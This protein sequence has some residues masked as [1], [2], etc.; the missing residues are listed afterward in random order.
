VSVLVP[1]HNYENFIERSLASALAQD[2]PAELLEIVVV[3]DG[4]TDGTA[5]V[6]RDV[7]VRHAGRIT[8]VQQAN[9]GQLATVARASAE[10][11]GELHTFLD[12][13]DEWLPTKVSRQV[14][15]FQAQPRTWLVFCDMTTIDV[16]GRVLKQSLYEP[17]EP[18]MDP[19]RLYARVLRSN[20]IYGGSSMYRAGLIT[21]LPPTAESWDWW[22]SVRTNEARALGYAEI[23]FVPQQLALYRQHPDNMLL[24]ATGERLIALRRRQLRFQLWAFRNMSLD[25]LSAGDLRFIAGGVEWFASTAM[26]QAGTSLA[27]L[28]T[29]D[30]DERELALDWHT[31]AEL[32]LG[33][34]AVMSAARMQLQAW[35]W[36]PLEHRSLTRFFELAA[37]G[38][39]VQ[40]LPHPLSGARAFVVMVD[41]EDLLAGDEMLRSYS[42]AMRGAQDVTLAIDAT[43][44]P[45]TQVA[46]QLQELVARCEL[47]E[48]EDIDLL[49]VVDQ[50]TPDQRHQMRNRIR[51]RYVRLAAGAGQIGTEPVFTPADLEQL[52]RV[53]DAAGPFGRGWA[54]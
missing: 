40:Q 19:G 44:V 6:I 41:V 20:V 28:V 22:L 24:G 21:D 46:S 29:V 16:E 53:T 12:A 25:P 3:D 48:R 35:A 7:M 4:S 52:R 26:Q 13:D 42:S 18:D 31:R 23:G 11:T 17:G 36:N 5:D 33:E 51:A 49:A 45:L 43:R 47:E 2:Y 34:G 54:P 39:G 8:L 30:D 27:E 9:Q 14:A 50:L 15:L 1:A 32:A 10:A 37:A 38:E